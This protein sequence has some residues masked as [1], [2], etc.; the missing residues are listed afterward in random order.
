VLSAASLSALIGYASAKLVSTVATTVLVVFAAE[1]AFLKW[2]ELHGVIT[3]NWC[4][5]LEPLGGC[6]IPQHWMS[7]HCTPTDAVSGIGLTT[8][9]PGTRSTRS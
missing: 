3:V 9:W 1:L 7:V 5:L 2:L 4:A 8:L 6:G